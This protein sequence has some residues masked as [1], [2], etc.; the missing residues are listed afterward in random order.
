MIDPITQYIL[1]EDAKDTAK[2]VASAAGSTTKNV[3]TSVGKAALN[4]AA[5]TSGYVASSFKAKL[6][7]K[8]LSDA[9]CHQLHDMAL[10][11]SQGQGQCNT[12]K[13]EYYTHLTHIC[14]D[15]H[16]LQAVVDQLN[17]RVRE[18]Q[19][20]RDEAMRLKGRILE[21]KEKFEH[22]KQIV[23]EKCRE[24]VEKSVETRSKEKMDTMKA[25]AK[26]K[27]KKATASGKHQTL[28]LTKKS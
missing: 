26:I 24:E 6:F 13:A 12:A 1:N 19:E 22:A 8:R 2:K 28:K 5:K 27:A 10:K 7:P 23:E 4:K 9:R 21:A 11:Y 3:A 15:G 14:N 18:P 25:K 20:L 17:K 16:K